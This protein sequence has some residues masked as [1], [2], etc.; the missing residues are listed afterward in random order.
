M[1]GLNLCDRARSS[2]ICRQLREGPL[3]IYVKSH[4]MWFK[5]MIRVCPGAFLWRF[6][7]H[8]QLGGDPGVDPKLLG[9]IPCLI[10]RGNASGSPWIWREG[11]LKYSA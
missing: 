11:G 3:L 2:D 6:S 4:L 1:L 10:W 5:C 9:G 7:T 8:V